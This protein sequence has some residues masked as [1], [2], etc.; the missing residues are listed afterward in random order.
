MAVTMETAVRFTFLMAVTM[1]TVMRFA[2]L[3]TVAVEN[4][5]VC[6]VPH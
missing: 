2:F 3:M 1:E 4:R 5:T 6:R